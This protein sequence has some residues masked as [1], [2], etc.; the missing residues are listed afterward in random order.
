M[1]D[2]ERFEG[3]F[4]EALE[5]YAAEAPTAVDAAGLT[6][7]VAEAE[8]R[9]AWWRSVALPWSTR[10]GPA[11]RLAI[12]LVALLALT[13]ALAVLAQ[14]LAPGPSG[15]VLTGQMT[16]TGADPTI[17]TAPVELDCTLD[18]A[19]ARVAGA[20]RIKLD[21]A[22][23]LGAITSRVGTIDVDGR[24]A[25]GLT[26]KTAPNGV[27]VGVAVLVGQAGPDGE[28]IRM[29]LLSTD[30]MHWGL[31]GSQSAGDSPPDAG[32]VE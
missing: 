1:A 19:G 4:A 5:R 25:G 21:A 10:A 9:R 7:S 16:C 14:R 30:G 28:T 13:W 12:A 27:A 2:T 23:A 17:V 32:D 29:R 31:L 8:A 24:W 11:A 26:V 22:I 18:L 15:G 3:R 20:A 6:R